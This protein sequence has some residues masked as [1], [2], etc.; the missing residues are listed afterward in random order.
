MQ[1]KKLGI[2]IKMQ[3]AHAA[4][5][6]L[7][8]SL[9]LALVN[10]Y[11]LSVLIIF[12]LLVLTFPI[13]KY[14][15]ILRTIFVGFGLYCL[16]GLFSYVLWFLEVRFSPFLICSSLF[17]CLLIYLVIGFNKATFKNYRLPTLFPRIELIALIPTLIIFFLLITPL[18]RH[19][20]LVDR[21][22]QASSGEDSVSHLI[23]VQSIDQQK[24][25]VLKKEQNTKLYDFSGYPQGWH[26]N[27]VAAKDVL[28]GVK[29]TNKA[30]Y[31]HRLLTIFLLSE[32][33]SYI[34]FIYLLTYLGIGMLSK[35]EQ[36]SLAAAVASTLLVMFTHVY[37]SYYLFDYGFFTAVQ[38]LGLIFAIVILLSDLLRRK[39]GSS[40]RIK[41]LLIMILSIGVSIT[42]SFLWPVTFFSILL[43]L[44]DYLK[45]I[46]YGI[47]RNSIITLI[48]LL[49]VGGLP[50]LYSL[51]YY[52]Q[53]SL[54]IH[55][56]I[57]ELSTP[58]VVGVV[59]LCITYILSQQAW[60]HI[61]LFYFII[62][63]IFW[64]VFIGIYQVI[65]SGQL[66]YYYHK[67]MYHL[68]I[69]ASVCFIP[70][71]ITFYY[72]FMSTV[73][74]NKWLVR[75]LLAGAF[76]LVVVTGI[77][78]FN[79]SRFTAD[80]DSDITIT[81]AA[82]KVIADRLEIGDS[83]KSIIFYDFCSPIDTY[84]GSRAAFALTGAFSA[85]LVDVRNASS[86]LIYDNPLWLSKFGSN[87]KQNDPVTIYTSPEF[88][89]SLKALTRENKDIVAKDKSTNCL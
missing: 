11:A 62:G 70:I 87:L 8:F 44:V 22:R 65:T 31:S 89:E 84:V 2:I 32:V 18:I 28:F 21:I 6:L 77:D 86:L 63:S 78:S 69:L 13:S 34:T 48:F 4:Y 85:S 24:S 17:V 55:G 37:S 36:Q 39:T 67:S 49:C 14:G 16:N 3:F 38:S 74:K 43:C 35:K 79:H 23:I 72:A 20:S 76:C 40:D 83:N 10:W 1:I 51:V 5:L 52:S 57:I 53:Q 71:C 45:Q 41:I 30:A 59:L 58:S 33:I 29:P 75:V 60:K 7:A 9:L 54:N 47:K 42:Y 27:I 88:S 64:S 25:Y 19:G 15:L 12:S 80:K 73:V 61:V 26:I 66:E 68:Y 56:D 50:V 46:K 81:R 82:A